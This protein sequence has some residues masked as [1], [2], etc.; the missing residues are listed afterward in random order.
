MTRYVDAPDGIKI[1]YEVE[2]EGPPGGDFSPIVLVHGFGSNR[3]INW[4]NTLWYQTLARAGRPIVAIDCRGHGQSGKPH[5]SA[6]YDEGAMA[7][8]IAAVLDELGIITAD[9]MGYSM[10]GFIA[11]RLMHDAPIRIRR[12]ILA[13]IGA[14]YFDTGPEWAEIVASGLLAPDPDSIAD[15]Q[16]REFRIFCERAGNDLKAMAACVRRPRRVFTHAELGLLPQKVLVVCGAQDTL[17]GAPEPLAGAFADGRAVLVPG[18]NHHSTVGDRLY[19][20][21]VLEFLSG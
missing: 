2:G 18:R 20:D 1:A 3:A 19:K 6:A 13:G 12:A 8:D 7:A 5:D 11:I 17:T 9:V 16:A 4:K 14:N 15:K 21:A 10:G